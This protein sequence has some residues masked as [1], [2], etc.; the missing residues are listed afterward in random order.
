MEFA[1]GEPKKID[2]YVF[3]GIE[4]FGL[5]QQDVENLLKNFRKNKQVRSKATQC[6]KL[7]LTFK[8]LENFHVMSVLAQRHN[9]EFKSESKILYRI[10]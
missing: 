2:V 10:I 7:F 8:I 1:W 5:L 6:Q 9:W 3:W 4:C